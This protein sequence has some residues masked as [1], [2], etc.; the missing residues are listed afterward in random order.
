MNSPY[1]SSLCVNN[2]NTVKIM[3]MWRTVIRSGSVVPA[4]KAMVPAKAI[5]NKNPVEDPSYL[6]MTWANMTCPLPHAPANCVPSL[7]HAML[8]TLPVLGFSRACDHCKVNYVCLNF[9][10]ISSPIKHA[11]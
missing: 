5:L 9:H 7:D 4:M 11:N 8:N 2:M 1:L 3:A 10:T 6:S